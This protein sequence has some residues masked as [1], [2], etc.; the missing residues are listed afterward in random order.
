MGARARLGPPCARGRIR[1]GPDVQ[2][3]LVRRFSLLSC[4]GRGWGGA[5]LQPAR[6]DQGPAFPHDTLSGRLA[7]RPRAGGLLH[8]L[9]LRPVRLGDAA[10]DRAGRR[11]PHLHGA[12]RDHGVADELLV[13][14]HTFSRPAPSG[15]A[16]GN[17]LP[18]DRLHAHERLGR[19]DLC[20]NVRRDRH[21]AFPVAAGDGPA[22]HAQEAH[23]RGRRLRPFRGALFLPPRLPGRLADRCRGVPGFYRHGGARRAPSR[24]ARGAPGD[25]ENRRHAG[26]PPARSPAR[27]ALLVVGRSRR[28][29]T[30]RLC[31]RALRLRQQSRPA[32][33][34]DGHRAGI[35]SLHLGG[36]RGAAVQPTLA[37]SAAHGGGDA[38]ARGGRGP[39]R[40]PPQ[41]S[42]A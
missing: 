12:A 40:F 35:A 31:G 30:R 14:P 32:A 17:A 16:V 20:R 10:A 29:C 33:H 2:S 9:H 21:G 42:R 36:A 19:S 28:F 6:D 24:E 26:A 23:F 11:L 15:V 37:A 27:D 8:H 5:L 1:A 3:L 4:L 7:R 41:I 39:A 38:R 34:V 13:R 18:P 25:R 22:R